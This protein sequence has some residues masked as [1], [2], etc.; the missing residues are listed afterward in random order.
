MYPNLPGSNAHMENEIS[1]TGWPV[2]VGLL[3]G[4]SIVRVLER[5]AP[6]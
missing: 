4:L 6:V 5:A 3:T 1:H 2:T